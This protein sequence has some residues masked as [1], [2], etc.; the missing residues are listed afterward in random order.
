MIKY[1]KIPLYV[2]NDNISIKNM[3]EIRII[4]T[5][6]KIILDYYKSICIYKYHGFMDIIYSLYRNNKIII[7]NK[8]SVKEW[9]R[10][11]QNIF[12]KP[13]SIVEKY[14]L[15][16]QNMKRD[17]K[18]IAVH[19]RTGFLSNLSKSSLWYSPSIYKEY[20]RVINELLIK[21][22]HYRIL[23]LSDSDILIKEFTKTYSQY[24]LNYSIAGPIT[25]P[26]YSMHGM[27]YESTY[28]SLACSRSK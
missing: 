17:R 3:K 2:L 9:T 22:I 7:S 14:I 5:T 19:I 26:H 16:F 25:N 23:L 15:Q 4:N 18:V 27:N 8:L 13:C 12:F 24:I 6:I 28:F 20:K 11:I 10:I 1:F 21:Y